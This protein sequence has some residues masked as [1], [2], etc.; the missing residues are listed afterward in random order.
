MILQ[1]SQRYSSQDIPNRG[2]LLVALLW[3]PTGVA[4]VTVVLSCLPFKCRKVQLIGRFHDFIHGMSAA[5]SIIFLFPSTSFLK[6]ERG[7]R[8]K[9]EN[10]DRLY[11]V[12]MHDRM[13]RYPEHLQQQ[14]W[15]DVYV[16]C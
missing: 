10:N 1:F 5:E 13:E 9:H 3:P 8:A 2:P 6:R 11:G 7:E 16:G 14:G 15:G 4:L 12:V